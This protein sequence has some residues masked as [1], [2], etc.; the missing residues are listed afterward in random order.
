[1]ID[2]FNNL[3]YVLSP[4]TVIQ[5]NKL[6]NK[7]KALE[8]TLIENAALFTTIKKQVEKLVCTST[9]NHNYLQIKK[10]YR[11]CNQQI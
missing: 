2:G 5:T 8:L 1:M 9:K 11:Q 10:K 4:L 3:R 6:E 7:I